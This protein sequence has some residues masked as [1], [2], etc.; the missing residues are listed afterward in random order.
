M[1]K[2]KQPTDSYEKTLEICFKGITGNNELL[3]NVRSAKH[4]LQ[5]HADC[6]AKLAPM[7]KL[8][9]IPAIRHKKEDDPIVLGNLKKSD[10]I[11]LYEN[12][13]NNNKKNSR[14]IYDSLMAA[15]GGKCPYCG[16]IG[17]PR[18]LDHYLPKGHYPQ[19]SVLPINLIPS[20]RDCNMDG[21]GDSFAVNEPEQ[22]LHPYL[23]NDRYFNE[24][25]IFAQYTAGTDD[26][27]GVIEYFVQAPDHWEYAQKLR[28]KKHFNDFNLGSRFSRQAASDLDPY[29]S[30]IQELSKQNLDFKEIND[31]IL[32]PVINAIPF[33]N[34][35]KRVM[36]LALMNHPIS[37]PR[38][39]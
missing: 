20:C 19:F 25:W 27:P 28:V 6:Y 22:I 33:I 29:L 8:H 31:V 39:K 15:A 1:L 5:N 32:K 2:L 14:H 37:L 34:H 13:F 24:Q 23:D 7:E 18:N 21:K 10:L 26:E 36:C 38:T 35:W 3:N 4:I 11:K 12:Y 9:V 17:N 30:Q 16:G